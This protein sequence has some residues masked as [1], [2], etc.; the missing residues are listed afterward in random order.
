[1]RACRK[2]QAFFYVFVNCCYALSC[3]SKITD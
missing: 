1:M 3:G 2:K